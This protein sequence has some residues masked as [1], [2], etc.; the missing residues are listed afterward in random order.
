MNALFVMNHPSTR[1]YTLADTC[2]CVMDVLPRLGLVA[3]VTVLSV[4]LLFEMLL[5]RTGLERKYQLCINMFYLYSICTKYLLK[6]YHENETERVSD[7]VN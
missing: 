4:E 3:L 7:C 6:L 5:K 1:F 2:A